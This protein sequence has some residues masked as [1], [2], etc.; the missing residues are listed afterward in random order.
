MAITTGA[1]LPHGADAVIPFEQVQRVD[2]HI[3]ISAPARPG[4]FI[5][6]PAED[7]RRGE[8][9]VHCG[10]VLRAATLALLAFAGRARLHVYRR[11]R[12]SVLCTG[13]ELVD[14]TA[15]PGHGQI[16]NSN[17]FTLTALTTE[18]GAEARYCGTAPDD[19]QVLRGLLESARGG[20]DLLVTTGGASAGERDLVK[21]VLE[22]L[23]VKFRFRAVAVRP[24][25]PMG[26]G[27]WDGLPVCVL[28]GNPAAAF[29]GF[30]EFVRP[31]LLRLAGRRLT[32]LPALRARLKGHLKSKPG[33]R[34]IVLAQLALTAA[35]LEVT[36]LA[37]QCSALVRT[38]A[39]AN[40]LIVLPEGLASFD[41]G[42][43]VEV[44][45]L[46]WDRAVTVSASGLGRSEG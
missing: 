8:L 15:A 3:L 38:S 39:E 2:D 43:T 26:F 41:P 4:D 17:A 5:F 1:P 11:P 14:V 45:V 19:R 24:G 6:P 25:K 33:R 37:N 30:H 29:V 10:D 34:Y 36:P 20:A 9:L 46:D 42:D 23:G 32:A 21:G 28:P 31:A 16:R 44:Q 35:G 27:T 12:V 22:E 40:A 7:V 18:C 13:N